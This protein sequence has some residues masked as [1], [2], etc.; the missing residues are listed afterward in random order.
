MESSV[1]DSGARPSS[2]THGGMLSI[3]A[4]MAEASIELWLVVSCAMIGGL[5]PLSGPFKWWLET[6]LE[7]FAVK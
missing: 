6:Y 4:R 1:V 3:Q 7:F 2:R 5:K